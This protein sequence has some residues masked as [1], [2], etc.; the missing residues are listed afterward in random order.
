MAGSSS[1]FAQLQM[2]PVPMGYL[3]YHVCSCEM[4]GLDDTVT[5]A[6]VYPMWSFKL[7]L[8]SGTASVNASGAQ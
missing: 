2:L 1:G 6:K 8:C 7:K 3:K 5:E 4:S